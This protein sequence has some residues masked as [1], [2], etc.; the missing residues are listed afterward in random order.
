MTQ[1]TKFKHEF[2]CT[3]DVVVVAA[4]R[5][6]RDRAYSD[7]L[8]NMGIELS[9]PGYLGGGWPIRLGVVESGFAAHA[10]CWAD[11]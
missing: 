9:K 4:S 11:P 10:Q 6:R 5:E 7:L 1:G 3:T 8:P 2:C